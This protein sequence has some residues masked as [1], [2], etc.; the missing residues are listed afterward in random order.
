MFD[1]NSQNPIPAV[2]P[3]INPPTPSS[4]PV[5][6]APV[7]DIFAATDSNIKDS[8]F[9]QVG[10]QVPP[11]VE[12]PMSQIGKV[13]FWHKWWFWV[14]LAVIIVIAGGVLWWQGSSPT[15]NRQ[16]TTDNNNQP[17]FFDQPQNQPPVNNPPP[18]LPIDQDSDGLTDAEEQTV[19][20]D[21]LK[22]DTDSDGLFDREEVKVYLTDPLKADTDGDTFADG[23]EIQNG[24]NPKGDGKLLELPV[25]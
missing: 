1:E 15:D 7:D 3:T 6:P 14:G 10:G 18:I 17:Q 21:P 25:Q 22:P 5:N 13:Y 23:V 20:T 4:T 9:T 12:I 24:Y 2:P 11:P 8:P 16:Q 19:G